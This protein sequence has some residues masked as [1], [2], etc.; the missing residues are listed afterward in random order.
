MIIK[1]C[2]EKVIQKMNGKQGQED[3]DLILTKKVTKKQAF[4]ISL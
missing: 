2:Y 1:N 3:I 4:A